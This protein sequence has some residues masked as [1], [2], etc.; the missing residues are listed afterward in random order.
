MTEKMN[1]TFRDVASIYFKPH[2]TVV[3]PFLRFYPN[4]TSLDGFHERID[5]DAVL[6]TVSLVNL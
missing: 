5:N 2:R 4:E 3:T 1:F 6:V